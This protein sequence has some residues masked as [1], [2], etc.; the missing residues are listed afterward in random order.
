MQEAFNVKQASKVEQALNKAD[1]ILEELQQRFE[2]DP[3]DM[4]VSQIMWIPYEDSQEDK[5]DTIEFVK[6]IS[7]K[8]KSFD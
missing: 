7:K 5:K 4:D 6:Y 8:N 1:M 3:Q 2:A